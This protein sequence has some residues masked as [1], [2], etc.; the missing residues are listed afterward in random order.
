M[1]HLL[2][3]KMSVQFTLTVFGAT[4]Y[5][6]CSNPHPVAQIDKYVVNVSTQK[7]TPDSAPRSEVKPNS[8][9]TFGD[10]RSILFKPCEKL[11]CCLASLDECIGMDVLGA[12]GDNDFSEIESKGY[13]DIVLYDCDASTLDEAD[14]KNVLWNKVKNITIYDDGNCLNPILLQTVVNDVHIDLTFLDVENYPGFLSSLPPDIGGLSLSSF[15]YQTPELIENTVL[16]LNK[17]SELEYLDIEDVG[18]NLSFFSELVSL[19]WLV[20]DMA[21]T[22]VR[23]LS[24]LVRFGA[25]SKLEILN[26]TGST[27]N[28]HSEWVGKLTNLKQLSMD[29]GWNVDLRNLKTNESL[30]FLY[31]W[32]AE[33]HLPERV[34]PE[35]KK[36]IVA[37]SNFSLHAME[38][39]KANHIDSDVILTD[40]DKMDHIFKDAVRVE[41]RGGYSPLNS[42]PVLV[43][44][45]ATDIHEFQEL[46]ELFEL[47]PVKSYGGVGGIRSG[48]DLAVTVVDKQGKF[49]TIGFWDCGFSTIRLTKQDVELSSSSAKKLN[50]WFVNNKLFDDTNCD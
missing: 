22:K 49:K 39:F 31:L 42:Q 3:R 10:A 9:N 27:V 19:R 26:L 45:N 14:F 24:K 38:N 40:Q 33:K 13:L 44:E 30:R 37:K 18:E 21:D 28:D 36:I 43:L 29:S 20:I 12:E 7:S 16:E 11:N 47:K 4:F 5:F 41:F 35:L 15:R 46:I 1:I 17:L 23:K 8:N 50:E 32:H 34:W 2:H 25:L 48:Y 6:A